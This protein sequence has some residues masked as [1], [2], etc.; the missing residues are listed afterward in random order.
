MGI[1]DNY[2]KEPWR[3]ERG[4]LLVIKGHNVTDNIENQV[5]H[6]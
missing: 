2:Y 3:S 4:Q 1:D 6:R 5:T